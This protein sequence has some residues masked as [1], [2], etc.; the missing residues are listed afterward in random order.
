MTLIISILWPLVSTPFSIPCLVFLEKVSGMQ[1]A[2]HGPTGRVVSRAERESCLK[3]VH[4]YA[5]N[6]KDVH[7]HYTNSGKIELTNSQ[8]RL[9]RCDYSLYNL[10]VTQY[11]KQ[12]LEVRFIEF[13][14]C[15]SINP[16]IAKLLD[17]IFRKFARG[18]EEIAQLFDAE[19]FKRCF[20]CHLHVPVDS[21]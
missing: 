8:T 15:R 11:W 10:S 12:F 2:T 19:T 17:G 1:D 3:V 6:I 20:R 16:V 4:G 21:M 14:E 9:V 13:K 18:G 7:K 5:G